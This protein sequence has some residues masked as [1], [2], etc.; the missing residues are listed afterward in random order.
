MNKKELAE[1]KKQFKRDNDHMTINRISSHYI[2]R[3]GDVIWKANRKYGEHGGG[4]NYVPDGDID[5]YLNMFKKTLG[6]QL[7]KTLV[8]YP[9]PN[10]ALNKDGAEIRLYNLLISDF[11][12]DDEID[13]YVD[14][15]K[16][17][18]MSKSDYLLTIA[19]CIYDIPQ[20]K[21]DVS[22]DDEYSEEAEVYRFMVA[23]VCLLD[24][25]EMGL[26][27]DKD[28]NIVEN[29]PAIHQFVTA[30]VDGFLFPVFNDRAP[31]VN[32]V[33]C[34]SKNKKEP[35]LNLIE[36]VLGCHFE[37]T[38]ED[39]SIKFNTLVTAV[40]GSRGRCGD[41]ASVDYSV[42]QGIHSKISNIINTSVLNTAMPELDKE[43]IRDI[44]VESGVT[45]EQM[46]EYDN[47]YDTLIGEETTL[48]ASNVIDA[49]KLS[50]KSPDVVVNVKANKS[51]KVVTKV[52][53]GKKCLVIALDENVEVQGINVA[54]K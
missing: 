21:N 23:S 10:E 20:K 3:E 32:S 52:I 13:E 37:M 19:H 53:D 45:D 30:P 54:V 26:F 43:T 5:F 17:Q 24:R 27:Y 1:I 48:K 31:D 4:E 47:M 44:F 36:N 12:D 9:F 15:F 29:F 16:A 33:L 42:M 38:S 14:F 22:E 46:E 41:G 2:S 6:G 50:L 7:G 49:S 39:E 40:A 18:Y 8:E 28:N 25:T 11:E 34:F 35:N 51:D